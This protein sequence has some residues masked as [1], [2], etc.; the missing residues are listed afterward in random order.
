MIDKQKEVH[1]NGYD[2]PER[3][4]H[5]D[6]H[7]NRGVSLTII[8]LL[9]GNIAT[10][11]WWASSI[12]SDITSLRPLPAEISVMKERLVK[13]ETTVDTHNRYFNKLNTTLDNFNTTID[14]IDREQAR[15]RSLI[16]QV[17]R[18]SYNPKK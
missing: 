6:W 15:R 17:E 1:S 4:D 12:N 3:R 18:G 8:L 10:S 14:R 7:L 2:G 16:D 11:I 5:V 9:L 13:L